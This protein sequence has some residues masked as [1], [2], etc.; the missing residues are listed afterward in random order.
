MLANARHEAF[1]KNR[2]AGLAQYDAYI[3]SGFEGNPTAASQIE[4]RP[5][6]RSRIQEL[7]AERQAARTDEERAEDDSVSE[8]NRD[9]VLKELK[10]NVKTAQTSGQISAANKAIELIMDIVGLAPKKGKQPEEPEATSNA[11]SHDDDKLSNVLDRIDAMAKYNGEPEP[12][13]E[14]ES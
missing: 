3:N 4:R 12:E 13:S 9:W 6:V 7:I 8:L 1:A 2:A 10:Q 11:P 14:D 5:E